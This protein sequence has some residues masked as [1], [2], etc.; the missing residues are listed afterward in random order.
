MIRIG[1]LWNPAQ[2][3]RQKRF[4]SLQC[5]KTFL[6]NS[7][8]NRKKWNQQLKTDSTW[9]V[10]SAEKRCSAENYE[11][12]SL[13]MKGVYRQTEK[14]TDGWTDKQTWQRQKARRGMVSVSKGTQ[15]FWHSTRRSTQTPC[16]FMDSAKLW[17]VLVKWGFSC[18]EKRKLAKEGWWKKVTL[19]RDHSDVHLRE[20]AASPTFHIQTYSRSWTPSC[21]IFSD[22]FVISRMFRVQVRQAQVVRE[23]TGV[24]D[25]EGHDVVSHQML[26]ERS[27][28]CFLCVSPRDI[29][30]WSDGRKSCHKLLQF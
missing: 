4:L 14:R 24:L 7:Q 2:F 11:K 18:T 17:K 30:C 28:F 27:G 5:K 22:A 13:N 23:L 1:L 19:R 3:E 8:H 6:H 21:H 16:K 9:R 29:W 15:S 20:K 10:L 12:W 26:L 25:W